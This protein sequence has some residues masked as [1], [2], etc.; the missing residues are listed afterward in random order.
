M[1]TLVMCPQCGGILAGS[2]D[3][4]SGGRRCSCSGTSKG[5]AVAESPATSSS[6]TTASRKVCVQCAKDV[7]TAKRMKDS[8][9]KYW[10]IECGKADQAKKGT[11]ASSSS[12]AVCP[13]C[14]QSFPP[15]QL[16]KKDSKYLCQGC[17]TI[18][19][20]RDQEKAGSLLGRLKEKLTGG[21]DGGGSDAKR[22][23]ILALIIVLLGIVAAYTYL[24][25]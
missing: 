11:T 7:T 24:A 12:G 19:L 3:E 14:L 4:M 8:K 25:P 18:R 13:D 17:L 21:G 2:A 15:V 22:T 16:I 10:C 1:S 5:V 20:R 6:S 23:R 9:G